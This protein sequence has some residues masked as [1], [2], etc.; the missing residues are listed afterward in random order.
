V[1]KPRSRR[2]ADQ[3]ENPPEF[4]TVRQLADLLQLTEMT[5][6]RKVKRAELPCH[7]IGRV[8]RFRR[9][10]IEKFLDGCRVPAVKQKRP[11]S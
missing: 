1:Q 6:Y 10:D 7:S 11:S 5:I 4:Y 3:K 8:K 9:S 2:E